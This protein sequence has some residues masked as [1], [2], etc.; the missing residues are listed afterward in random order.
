M[1]ELVRASDLEEARTAP[2]ALRAL[3]LQ[4]PMLAHQPL[5]PLAIDRAPANSREASAAT[6]RVPSVGLPARVE[7]D[8][9]GRVQRPALALRR[10]C[11]RR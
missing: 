10:A 9:I 6:I 11:G 8:P 1:P 2:A 3:G 7:H 4:Q 5:H